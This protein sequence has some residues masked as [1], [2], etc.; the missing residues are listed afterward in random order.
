M[1]RGETQGRLVLYDQL[2]HDCPFKA[3][4]KLDFQMFDFLNKN[5]KHAGHSFFKC[6][7]CQVFYCQIKQA[8]KIDH[9]GL[10]EILTNFLLSDIF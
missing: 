2:L 4:L 8:N 6:Q 3:F 5:A 10:W 9:F 7:K 1:S